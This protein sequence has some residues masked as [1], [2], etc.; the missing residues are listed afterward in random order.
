M[1]AFAST[2]VATLA[3]ATPDVAWTSMGHFKVDK[4]AFLEIGNFAGSEKF[5]LASSFSAGP[6]GT[7]KVFVIPGVEA[8]VTAGSV[9]HLKQ[10]QLDMHGVSLQWPNSVTIIPDD[11]FGFR[12]IMVPDGFLV[13][14]HADG[15]LYII[16]MD[17][18]D[19]TKSQS[20]TKITEYKKGYFY[21]MG[22]WVDL[23]GDGRLDWITAR[24]NAKADGGELVWFEHPVEGLTDAT[25]TEHIICSGP[26]VGIE[27]I[28][29]GP[30]KHE[31][32]VFAAE[33]FNEK[34]AYYRVSTKTGDLVGSHIIDDGSILSAYSVTFV[35]L[36]GDG[37][38][39]LMVNN[40]ETDDSTNGIWSYDQPKHWEDSWTKRELASDF[41]NAFSVFVPNMAPGF[42]YAFYPKVA[43][44]GHKGNAAHILVAGDGD[45]TAWLMTNTD[46]ENFVWDRDTIH[47]T[48]GTVGALAFADLDNDGWNEVWV[49]DYDHSYMEVFRFH[50][51]E[52]SVEFLQ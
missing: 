16:K 22:H 47:E 13:P 24:S 32:V 38:K 19:I 44:E 21:H 42:P 9:D 31:I 12:A 49:P 3:T 39:E 34:V 14:G 25:W 5:L 37:K 45:H 40:H 1:K 15:G 46:K 17:D 51:I 27:V 20:V 28:E 18:E 8:A 6:L 10:H 36:N 26:D 7:G 4:A 35:D 2:M 30:W 43:D 11:V 29:D 41:K 23:N 50:A 48:R 33:F 52:E